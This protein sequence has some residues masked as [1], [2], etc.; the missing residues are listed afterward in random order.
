MFLQARQ[1]TPRVVL[2]LRLYLNENW[3]MDSKVR[4]R[5]HEMRTQPSSLLRQGS[6]GHR[7]ELH[8]LHH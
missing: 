8:P 3:L 5:H 1:S 4:R 2:Y 7:H 6:Q